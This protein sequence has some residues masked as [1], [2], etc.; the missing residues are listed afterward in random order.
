[1]PKQIPYKVLL[2]ALHRRLYL[3]EGLE[4]RMSA[5]TRCELFC[6]VK[7][8]W[9][10]MEERERVHIQNLITPADISS[11]EA[12]IKE[13]GK[14]RIEIVT[15]FDED[16]LFHNIS[17]PPPIVY[18]R[19]RLPDPKRYPYISVVGSRRATDYGR[20]MAE[21][22][23][24]G[25]ASFGVT[26]V[27]GLA[28]G[29][30]SEAHRAALSLGLPTVA[31]LGCGINRSYPEGNQR[32][33]EEISEGGAVISEFPWGTPPLRHNFPL[34]NRVIGGLS[35]ATVVVEA[36]I[37]SGS[38]ITAKWAADQGRE[39]FAVPGNI[40]RAMSTGTNL[41]IKD[42]AH[43]AEDGFGIA[44]AL[45]L[46]R[47]V[48][49]G[50]SKKNPGHEALEDVIK[51]AIINYLEGG[52]GNLDRLVCETGLSAV[53]LLPMITEIE[54]TLSTPQVYKGLEAG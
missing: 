37:K 41:L 52:E 1:M 16:Y 31:V 40:G 7:K 17:S 28:Y 43:L 30:D 42:G 48:T 21:K 33:A 4:N 19:G 46:Q 18:I 45:R 49:N 36:E 32:L 47:C 25:L 12:I 53:D 35:R 2:M 34:R 51:R 15:Q 24:K 10:E 38:L 9:R 11:A 14:R 5:D 29:I 20:K 3:L 22:I 8:R 39:V 54:L 50:E 44:E 13:A 23:V 6:L 26:I 27:S